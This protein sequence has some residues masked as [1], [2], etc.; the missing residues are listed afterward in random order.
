M[1]RLK[2]WILLGA[3][4]LAAVMGFIGLSAGC[5]C[6]GAQ[7]MTWNG[8]TRYYRLHAPPQAATQEALP[9]IIALHQF[10]D[11]ARGMER[12]TGFNAIADRDGAIVA[13]P[14]GRFRVWRTDTRDGVDDAGFLLALVDRIA[15]QYRVDPARIYVTGASAGAMMAQYLATQTDR[16]AA[17]APVMGSMTAGQ[18]AQWQPLRPLPV[19]MIHGTADPVIPYGGGD[20]YA[21]PGRRAAFMP[22]EENAAWWA[23]KN[24]CGETPLREMLPPRD[25]GNAGRVERIAYPCPEEAPVALLSV[26]GGGHTWPGAK[27]WYPGC[28][29]GPVSPQ[30]DA[31]AEIW[32]FFKDIRRP[33][34]GG[35]E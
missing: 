13:Y 21:G 15:A 27:N 31:S 16:L 35:E 28:I 20:T 29:V 10:S 1:P 11:T 12:L 19:L 2:R 4:G 26:G 33:E 7:R 9:L 18:A 14:Q 17:I 34:D 6:A 25:P 30:L 22:V 5:G 24:G 3:L 23:A 32:A 8:Y